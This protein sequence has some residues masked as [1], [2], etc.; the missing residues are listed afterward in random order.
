MIHYQIDL[1]EN[2]YRTI[3]G[4]VENI[5]D[6]KSFI[7]YDDVFTD[8]V[9]YIHTDAACD[10]SLCISAVKE[11]GVFLGLSNSE[12]EYLSLNNRNQLNEIVDVWGDDLNVSRGLFI[13]PEA[14]WKGICEFASSGNLYQG[15]EWIDSAEI[16]EEGNYII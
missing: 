9:G 4:S 15:I 5:N 7:F 12:A 10:V 13:S 11:Y 6:L 3:Q 16:P 14:A 1:T 2:E 8:C